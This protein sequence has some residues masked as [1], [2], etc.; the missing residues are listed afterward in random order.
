MTPIVPPTSDKTAGGETEMRQTQILAPRRWT[1]T[2]TLM[3]LSGY[4]ERELFDWAHE[5]DTGMGMKQTLYQEIFSRYRNLLESMVSKYTRGR[6]DQAWDDFYQAGS[7]GV[8]YAIRSY[9]PD[10]GMKFSTWAYPNVKRELIRHLRLSEH[11]HLPEKVFDARPQ[12]LRLFEAGM[13][14]DEAAK[15]MGFDPSAIVGVRQPPEVRSL[16]APLGGDP[17]AGQFLDLIPDTSTIAADPAEVVGRR[18]TI[19]AGLRCLEPLEAFVVTRMYGLDGRGVGTHAEVAAELSVAREKVRGI[20][21][22]ALD[23]MRAQHGFTL[24]S[25]EP[26]EG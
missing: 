6:G 10:A 17:D 21:L 18:A 23:K 12:L 24:G 14:D 8:W 15:Q 25:V 22:R 26:H 2:V 19:R 9:K 5:P 13:T 4:T 3:D 16:F 11:K 1:E 20:H 7:M